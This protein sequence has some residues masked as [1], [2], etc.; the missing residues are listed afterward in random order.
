M[1]V[2]SGERDTS[3]SDGMLAAADITFTE[4]KTMPYEYAIVESP[5]PPP[6]TPPSPTPPSPFPPIE[7]GWG[8]GLIVGVAAGGL[9]IVLSIVLIP[10]IICCC[11]MKKKKDVIPA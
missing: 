9:V 6:P 5:L 3:Y 1:Q 11:C 8:I 4:V 7:A 2:L 10:V